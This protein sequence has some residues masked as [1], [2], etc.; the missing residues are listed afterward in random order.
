[1]PATGG[2]VQR[3]VR[4]AWGRASRAIGSTVVGAAH[5]RCASAGAATTVIST[6]PRAAHG[7]AEVNRYDGRALVISGAIAARADTPRA[8]A[9]GV[10][11]AHIK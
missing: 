3:C 10:H 7:F 2:V 11:A 8:S 6:A 4:G 9:N 5:N 1:M